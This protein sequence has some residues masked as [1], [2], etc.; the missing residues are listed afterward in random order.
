MAEKEDRKKRRALV[1]L[2][3]VIGT[4]IGGGVAFAASST[5]NTSQLASGAGTVSAC[6]SEFDLAF[7]VPTYD[8]STETYR[9]STIDFSNVAETC[10]GQTMDVTVTDV[11]GTSLASAQATIAATSGTLTLDS[12]VDASATTALVAAIY[13]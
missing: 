6:D 13:Q 12:S 7:G 8:A 9:V 4:V 10:D 3:F 2:P 5:I 1:V 11:A